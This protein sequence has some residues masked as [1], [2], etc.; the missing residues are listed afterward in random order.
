MEKN[1]I[2]IDGKEYV[3]KSTIGQNKLAQQSKK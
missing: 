3:L 1:E 2:V